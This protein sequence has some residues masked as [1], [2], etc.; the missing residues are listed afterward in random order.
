M[1]RT[2]CLRDFRRGSVLPKPANLTSYRHLHPTAIRRPGGLAIALSPTGCEPARAGVCAC[3]FVPMSR[4]HARKQMAIALG[5]LGFAIALFAC[6]LY[7][8][9]LWLTALAGIA[10][11]AYW[12]LSRSRVLRR[13]PV[14]VWANQTALALSV[15]VAIEA[16][17]Y[18]LG[19]GLAGSI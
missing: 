19:L 16:G 1:R 3:T 13:L 9:P 6:G 7:G 17:A 11:L 18:W 8:A 4:A 2:E 10:M 14:K 5:D 12:S 15:I